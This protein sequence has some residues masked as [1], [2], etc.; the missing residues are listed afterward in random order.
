MSENKVNFMNKIV[1]E[2]NVATKARVTHPRLPCRGCTADCKN[3]NDC[4]GLLWR[5][6][7]QSEK[8]K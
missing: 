7:S 3:Y 5:M 2:N 6:D 1:L 8:A 4:D